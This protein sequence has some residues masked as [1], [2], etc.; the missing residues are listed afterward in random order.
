MRIDGTASVVIGATGGVVAVPGRGAG[1]LGEVQIQLGV[2]GALP[3][4]QQVG[5]QPVEHEEHDRR[6]V[7][8]DRGGHGVPDVGVDVHVPVPEDDP[9]GRR[10]EHELDHDHHGEERGIPQER[11]EGLG[12]VPDQP[13]HQPC[14]PAGGPATGTNDRS[15]NSPATCH[16]ASEPSPPTSPACTSRSQ[17][18]PASAATASSA[19]AEAA[20]PSTTTT[21]NAM[22]S[23]QS[24]PR[25][26]NVSVD[27]PSDESIG[28]AKTKVVR[29]NSSSAL[30]PTSP[31]ARRSRAAAPTV[32]PARRRRTGSAVPSAGSGLDGRRL[33]RG[34]HAAGTTSTGRRTSAPTSPSTTKASRAFPPSWKRRGGSSPSASPGSPS[35]PGSTVVTAPTVPF[36]A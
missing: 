22:P 21:R 25:V 15:P 36:S 16:T 8:A 23:V 14:E 13:H 1:Q 18:M 11:P 24:A 26:M 17:G 4:E 29:A 10:Q 19:T 7:V 3:V 34:G 35:S 9:A 30:G 20:G 2:D 33:G 28:L 5:G 27:R 12:A 32:Q 31:A 6:R